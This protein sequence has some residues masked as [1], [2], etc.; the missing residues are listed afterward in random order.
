MAQKAKTTY[1]IPFPKMLADPGLKKKELNW[2]QQIS[3]RTK[4]LLV[5]NI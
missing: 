1:Y 3:V 2:G 4:V 5:L